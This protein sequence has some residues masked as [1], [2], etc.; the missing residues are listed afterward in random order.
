MSDTERDPQ[1]SRYLTQS[2]VPDHADGFWD[3][4]DKQ[5]AT[6]DHGNPKSVPAEVRTIAPLEERQRDQAEV[7]R[8]SEDAG[9]RWR[10]GIAL[11]AAAGVL[12]LGLSILNQ[13]KGGDRV[14]TDDPVATSSTFPSSV[15]GQNDALE[16][17]RRFIDALGQ[18]NI[19]GARAAM[20][21]RSEAYLT[22]TTGSVDGFLREA[23]EGYGSLAG[24]QNPE[25]WALSTGENE[26]VVII[27][28]INP[29]AN[30]EVRVEAIPVIKAESAD[31]WFVEPWAL[32]RDGESRFDL[33]SP[34]PTPVTPSISA[35]DAVRVSVPQAGSVLFGLDRDAL[36]E[37]NSLS[38]Q[39]NGWA[40]TPKS[41]PA[42]PHTLVIV[43]KTDKIF[44]ALA[45]TVEF[46]V[47]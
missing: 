29:V 44:N 34:D 24:L 22:A 1:M 2:A 10:R 18:G 7:R 39:Q 12:V 36:V 21:P 35:G 16:V 47:S 23:E 40:W 6:I 26:F 11:A 8:M 19:A 17:T 20:G 3:E 27:K 33:T 37:G 4:L 45:R 14:V 46:G 38:S 31:A 28:G 41:V 5:M 30:P 32:D 42:G 13:D 43:Y 15:A 25:M 9:P